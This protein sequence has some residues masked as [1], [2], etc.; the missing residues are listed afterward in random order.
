VLGELNQIA[1]ADGQKPENAIRPALSC[2]AENSENHCPPKLDS[3]LETRISVSAPPQT[4]ERRSNN[5]SQNVH[6]GLVAEAADTQAG[7]CNRH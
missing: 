5:P 6:S 4:L 1:T 7:S 3:G 2:P